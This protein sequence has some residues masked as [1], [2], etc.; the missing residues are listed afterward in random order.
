M[1]LSENLQARGFVHQFSGDSLEE[2]VDGESRT[3]Y[4]GV[5]PTAASLTIGNL[6]AYMLARHLVDAGHTPILL[7]GGGTGMIGDPGGR[8]NERTLLDEET[9]NTNIAGIR[10]QV[11]RILGVENVQVVNNADWLG[12]LNLIEFLRDV[13]KH[14]TVNSM[15]KKDIVKKRLEA[16]SPIS[17]TELSYSLLQAYDFAHLHKEYGC[18][19]Q[20]AGADQWTNIL[21]GIEY[22]R[23]TTGE[24]VYGLTNPIIVN[25]LTGKKFGKSEDGALWLDS[26]LTT[27]Y[28]LYQYLFNTED[29]SV[30]A[31]L[32][33]YTLR[34]LGD[35]EE[36]LSTTKGDPGGRAAQKMLAH[37]VVTFVHGE[38][39][40]N[41]VQ[42][43]S[44]ILFGKKEL[45]SID[46]S[47][48]ELL[49]KEA[50][51]MHVKGHT[52]TDILV[53]S[54]LAQSKKEAR[55][56]IKDEC[57][58]IDDE[59]ISDPEKQIDIKQPS[60]LRKGKKHVLVLLP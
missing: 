60:L 5:D 11:E 35:I 8:E 48:M 1:K 31:L 22:I 6:A 29:E 44:A 40:A 32:K 53:E 26:Q 24:T 13:G 34:S 58:S 37:D 39:T 45:S 41:A 51:T 18:T 19:L 59:C 52:A 7:V 21:S 42:D 57:V 36:V 28:T 9:L 54:G 2:I 17:F 33:I 30:E 3:F 16:E 38:D 43:V 12:K 14:F 47:E 50:P 20:I 46:V 27:P 10:T 49:K 23:K 55:D 4:L 56:L 25:P 15:V